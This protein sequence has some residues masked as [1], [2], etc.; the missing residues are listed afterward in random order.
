M[1]FKLIDQ[2]E[3]KKITI[4]QN[5]NLS[6]KNCVAMAMYSNNW[7]I[8]LATCILPIDFKKILTLNNSQSL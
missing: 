7:A 8:N 4:A 6:K 1:D 3:S 2:R 5:Q